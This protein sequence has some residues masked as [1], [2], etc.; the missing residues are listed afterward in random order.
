[1]M[2]VVHK[3]TDTIIKAHTCKTTGMFIMDITNSK[4]NVEM[5]YD[6]AMMN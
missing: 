1:M 5:K 4:P 6:V 2:G 3:D